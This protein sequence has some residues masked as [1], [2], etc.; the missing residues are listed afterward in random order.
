MSVGLLSSSLSPLYFLGRLQLTDMSA[1]TQP[2][3]GVYHERQ[4]L[5]HCM[6]VSKDSTRGF[7]SV[8]L[9]KGGAT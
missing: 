8:I 5:Q 6:W 1:V 7:D 9:A 4:R 3:S 2:T